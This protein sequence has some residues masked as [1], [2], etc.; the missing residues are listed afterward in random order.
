V[1]QEYI[2]TNL[3]LPLPSPDKA[4]GTLITVEESPYR[5]S[6]IVVNE[7]KKSFYRLTLEEKPRRIK[8][9]EDA[10]W[11]EGIL[12]DDAASEMLKKLR[13]KAKKWDREE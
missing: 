2:N 10:G 3:H 13:V 11:A 9:E 6:L 7:G 12:P 4:S 5:A 8:E 1:I